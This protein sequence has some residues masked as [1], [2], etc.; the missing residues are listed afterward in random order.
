MS[1]NIVTGMT[2]QA[3]ITSDDDRMR[4]AAYVG[5]DKFA[6]PFGSD[7]KPFD[8]EIINN[9]LIRIKEGMLMNQGTQMGIELTDYE[10]V[11]IENGTSGLNRNDLI[12]MRYEKQEDTGLESARLV[13]LRGISSENPVDPEYISGNILDGGDLIDD[14]PLYRVNIQSLSIASLSQLFVVERDIRTQLKNEKTRIDNFQSQSSLQSA[15]IKS[16]ELNKNYLLGAYGITNG[17]EIKNRA[18]NGRIPVNDFNITAQSRTLDP[19]SNIDAIVDA[20][21]GIINIRG[22]GTVTQDIVFNIGTYT[23]YTGTPRAM[24]G[25][26]PGGSAFGYCLKIAPWNSL[27]TGNGVIINKGNKNIDGANYGYSVNGVNGEQTVQIRISKGTEIPKGGLTFAPMIIDPYDTDIEK[28]RALQSAT[29]SNFKITVDLAHAINDAKSNL[30]LLIGENWEDG[31]WYNGGDISS[32]YKRLENPIFLKAGT[33]YGISYNSGISELDNVQ[34]VIV[35]YNTTNTTVLNRGDFITIKPKVDSSIYL[36][37]DNTSFPITEELLGLVKSSLVITYG[38][39]NNTMLV[40][41]IDYNHSTG[42]VTCSESYSRMY[43]FCANVGNQGLRARFWWQTGQSFTTFLDAVLELTSPVI[44]FVGFIYIAGQISRIR[45]SIDANDN[46]TVVRDGE[47]MGYDS[48]WKTIPTSAYI[49]DITQGS[50]Y[51]IPKYRR[52]GNVVYIAGAFKANTEIV[53]TGGDK[54]LIK[55]PY[56]FDNT[57]NSAVC[58]VSSY[59]INRFRLSLNNTDGIYYLDISRYGAGSAINIPSGTVCRMDISYITDDRI[60]SATY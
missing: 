6:F 20:G 55:L 53:T 28:I 37:A 25:C 23:F 46:I 60:Y 32:I 18:V 42:T 47:N 59:G 43:D 34:V 35:E 45:V 40:P 54:H 27:D 44:H 19:V 5:T 51:Q 48:G 9:N 22:F 56:G 2:G 33:R 58:Q 31:H 52:I 50:N 49:A 16:L 11:V 1:V 13:V 24:I 30:N 15:K 26:P 14:T 29:S 36:Q 4:N 3:H 38:H 39:R 10:D 21:M 17:L 7:G 12:V 41:R 8:Y 57:V